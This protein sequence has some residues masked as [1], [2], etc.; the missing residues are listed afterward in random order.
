MMRIGMA[1]LL[2]WMM[3]TAAHA[4]DMYDTIDR[5]WAEAEQQSRPVVEDGDKRDVIVRHFVKKLAKFDDRGLGDVRLFAEGDAQKI[6]QDKQAELQGLVQDLQALLNT[7]QHKVRPILLNNLKF[8]RKDSVAQLNKADLSTLVFPTKYNHKTRKPIAGIFAYKQNISDS[9]FD[10]HMVDAGLFNNFPELK[11]EA[12]VQDV[13][14]MDRELAAFWRIHK[15]YQDGMKF[16]RP[17]TLAEKQSQVQVDHRV[18]LSAVHDW[19]AYKREKV[20]RKFIRQLQKVKKLKGVPDI[21]QALQPLQRLFEET[22]KPI[23]VDN[24]NMQRKDIGARANKGDLIGLFYDA[25]IKG[26]V[27]KPLQKLLQP[28]LDEKIVSEHDA[29]VTQALGMENTLFKLRQEHI[30]YLKNESE[31]MW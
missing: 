29:W 8:K 17:K 13:L 2:A 23:L 6:K 30:A 16:T 22:V 7:Y 19:P 11:H 18:V 26:R 9:W 28:Y 25:H 5:L 21:K 14:D 15:S 10:K 4:E 31:L 12:W 24:V 20:V 3:L 27:G 1:V